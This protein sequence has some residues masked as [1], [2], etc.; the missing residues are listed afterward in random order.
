MFDEAMNAGRRIGLLATFAPAVPS[1]SE[2][3]LRQAA[4]AGRQ[5]ELETHCV[6]AAH[7]A[8][9]VGN[10]SEHDALVVSGLAALAHCDAIMLAHF[11]TATALPAARAALAGTGVRVL[12][13]PDAG[14][15]RMKELVL[16][17]NRG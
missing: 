13:A 1:M 10:T 15:A 6:A 9:R 12:A 4:S 7:A 5:V 8:A 17:R 16:E 11:S 2:A 3:F 14:V